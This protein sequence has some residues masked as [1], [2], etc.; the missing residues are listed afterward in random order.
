M[1]KLFGIYRAEISRCLSGYLNKKREDWGGINPWVSDVMG[2]LDRLST[3]GKMIRGSLT[4]LSHEMFG[5]NRT[6][7]A[8]IIASALEL[9]QTAVLVHDDII[10]RDNL[11]RGLPAMHEQYRHVAR[12]KRISENAR[13]GNSMA[14]CA[15]DIGFF[16]VYDMLSG[17]S[18]RGDSL[19]FILSY[20]SRE[21]ARVGLGEMADINFGFSAEIPKPDDIIS[22]Y[23][24]KT[25]RYSFSLPFVVGAALAGQNRKILDRLEK[26]GENLGL[27]YQIRD[28]ELGIYGRNDLTGKPVG[29]DISEGKKT[30]YY[31][32]LASNCSIEDRKKMG[33]IFGK[34]PLLPRDLERVKIMIDKSGVR[35][36]VDT[37][38]RDNYESAGNIIR[39]LPVERKYRTIVGSLTEFLLKRTK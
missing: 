34:K 6:G 12:E 2:R 25:A 27:I 23:I 37:I 22:C 32:L 7:D 38:I 4:M 5:G 39:V 16:L 1:D 26:L 11:R 36:M 29:S 35:K 31:S 15:A 18:A 20:M 8:I 17:L 19:R 28:D 13:F 9:F 14:I 24:S 3:N 21:F 10:D 30:L 33:E